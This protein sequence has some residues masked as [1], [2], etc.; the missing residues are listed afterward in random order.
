VWRLVRVVESL[1]DEAVVGMSASVFGLY[2][3]LRYGEP[4]TVSALSEQLGA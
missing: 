1:V 3:Q 4:V 2:S